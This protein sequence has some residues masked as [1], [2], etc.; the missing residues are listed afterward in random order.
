MDLDKAVE[1]LLA[2]GARLDARL[3]ELAAETKQGF[4]ETKASQEQT[5]RQL[6]ILAELGTRVTRRAFVAIAALAQQGRATEARLDQLGKRMDDF[7]QAMQLSGNGRKNP[8]R[9]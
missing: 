8:P 1:F 5:D 6:K 7:V 3:A 2:E 4:A 9:N